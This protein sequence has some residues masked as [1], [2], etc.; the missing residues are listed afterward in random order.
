MMLDR[1][2]WGGQLTGPSFPIQQLEHLIQNI[3]HITSIMRR[4]TVLLHL[5]ALFGKI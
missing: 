3:S 5:Q 4:G 2:I 1:T